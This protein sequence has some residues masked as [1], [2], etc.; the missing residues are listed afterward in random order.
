MPTYDPA[1][2][3]NN[4]YVNYPPPVYSDPYPPYYAPAATFF[5][6]AFVGA[7]FAYG[8]DWDNDDIDIDNDININEGDINIGS[9]NNQHRQDQGAEQLQRRPQGRTPTAR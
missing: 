3:V 5:A 8:F 2:I 7:A 6:G 9:G 1:P 4:T